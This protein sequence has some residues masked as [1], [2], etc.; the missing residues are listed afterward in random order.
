MQLVTK[1]DLVCPNCKR[2][3]TIT[4]YGLFGGIVKQFFYRKVFNWAL[5][6]RAIKVTC[7]KCGHQWVK[8]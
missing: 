5:S 3:L 2:N 6:K 4:T 1:L 7:H 8:E